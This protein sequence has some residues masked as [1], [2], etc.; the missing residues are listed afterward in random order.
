MKA[1]GFDAASVAEYMLETYV[2]FTFWDHTATVPPSQHVAM[3]NVRGT[4][5]AQGNRSFVYPI[6]I[7][8]HLVWPLL[9]DR[10]T[11]AEKTACSF[12]IASIIFHELGVG[13]SPSLFLRSH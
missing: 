1:L 8:A 3:G 13:A 10:Y 12:L 11:A 6:W 9:T 5:D 7:S 4:I 2:R